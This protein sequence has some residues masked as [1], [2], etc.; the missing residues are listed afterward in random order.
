MS[1]FKA[2]E[3]R[4][5]FHFGIPIIVRHIPKSTQKMLLSFLTAINLAS[6]EYITYEIIYLVKKLL[7]YFVEQYQNIFGLRHMTTNIHSLLHV[8]E[9]LKYTGP[10]WMYSTF[11]Y[12]GIDKN[13]INTV[14]GTVH[15]AKQLIRQ[16]VLF[17]DAIVCHRN[18]SYPLSLFTFNEQLLN[19]K[20]SSVHYKTIIDGCS[21]PKNVSSNLYDNSK[22]GIAT[23]AQSYF[24]DPVIFFHSVKISN[25]LLKTTT[26][27][28]GK[29]CADK[30]ISFYFS[31][32]QQKLGLI[33]AIVKSKQNTIRLLIEELIEKRPDSSKLKF[34]LENK[35]IEVPNIFILKRSN[36]FHLKHPKCVIKKH[37]MIFRPGNCVTVLE[38]PNLKDNS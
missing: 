23:I 33:R 9:S 36:V 30:C 38:Y 3:F 11:S 22:N 13:L 7:Y 18:L 32:N 37:A 19:R 1:K 12:E 26:I 21:L 14:H 8:S 20:Q 31:D 29:Q 16:H 17:R 25:V 34:K 27:S 35:F 6:S 15:F 28:Y 5:L 2:S 10:L 4:T 24:E